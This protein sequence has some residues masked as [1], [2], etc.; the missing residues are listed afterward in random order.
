MQERK[1]WKDKKKAVMGKVWA[2]PPRPQ[3]ALSTAHIFGTHVYPTI[4]TRIAFLG[5]TA[6]DPTLIISRS[7]RLPTLLPSRFT[8]QVSLLKSCILRARLLD[9]R[10]YNK[11]AL[12][13]TRKRVKQ[14]A[15]LLFLPPT[16]TLKLRPEPP[17]GD[18]YFAIDSHPRVIP[19]TCIQ[20]QAVRKGSLLEFKHHKHRSLKTTLIT[21][22]V[23]WVV[24]WI[25]C[26]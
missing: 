20:T 10:T 26:G 22:K 11:L 6:F 24:Q 12:W 4:I 9:V 17:G 25:S 1:R 13:A 18:G 14:M 15:P 5:I 8:L 7:L 3:P 21:S 16:D 19:V 2:S 23:L